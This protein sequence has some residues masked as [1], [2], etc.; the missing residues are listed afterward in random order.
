MSGLPEVVLVVSPRY[1]DD[2]AMGVIAAGM[3]PRAERTGALPTALADPEAQILQSPLPDA[4]V[5]IA[6]VDAR[7]ALELGLAA[8]RRLA[9]EIARRQGGLLLLLSRGDLGNASLA[10]DVGAT[11]VLASPFS[12][13][14]LANALRVTVQN[15]DRLLVT[16]DPSARDALTGLA[17]GDHLQ[18]WLDTHQ[19]VSAPRVLM[20][21]GV[22]RIGAT[23]AA[24]GR[25][26]ADE[27]LRMVAE[28]LD[29]LVNVLGVNGGQP[30][31]IA[32][33]AAAEFAVAIAAD[34]AEGD[35]A[36]LGRQIVAAITTRIEA[37][38]REIH[39]TA[40]IG[41][42]RA[43]AGNTDSTESLMRKGSSALATARASAPGGI[44]TFAA[45]ADSD[46]LLRMADLV[47]DLH[48][49]IENDEITLL[50]QPLLD[51]KSGRIAGVEALVRWSHRNFGLLDAETLLETAADAELAVRLGRHIRQRAMQLAMAWP[52]SMGGIR[53][54]LNI[55]AGDLAVPGF[56]DGLLT[57]VAVSGLPYHRLT[58]EITEG[59]LIANIEMVSI[60]L[61]DLRRLGI[62]IV[63]DDFGTGYSSLA[64]LARLPIDGIKLDRSFTIALCRNE[65]EQ[66]VVTS[67]VALARQLGLSVVAEGVEEPAQLATAAAAGVDLVQ[68]FEIAVPLT[69][70]RL[71]EL[72]ETW[73]VGDTFDVA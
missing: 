29:R 54:S 52:P 47:A 68:G 73:V 35:V 51:L 6:V 5:R 1:G 60:I 48:R 2:V 36:L 57:A 28:R 22:G 7:G 62:K 27:A 18:S 64:W 58:L 19:A 55:T 67:V 53:L 39:L 10:R 46:N 72:H 30:R 69:S 11:N 12:A 9:P 50:F 40:R 23:N 38:G 71:V 49:A 41:I 16:A 3:E 65:R 42:A 14:A 66:I 20:M 34:V 45:D 37:G 21:I 56:A 8:A 32:R 4:R 24:Y 44:A 59:A 25:V 43:L 61:S 63:L 33:L 26:V 13:A 70:A 31:L 15:A 17:T